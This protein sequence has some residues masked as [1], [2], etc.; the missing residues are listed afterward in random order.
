MT[1]ESLEKEKETAN[2]L[3]ILHIFTDL[4]KGEERR[5]KKELWFVFCL[6]EKDLAYSLTIP[7][8]HYWLHRV[9]F[10]LLDLTRR[11]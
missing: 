7:S 10:F 4:F 2:L 11:L 6:K 9:Q 3:L 1:G 5:L 8:L